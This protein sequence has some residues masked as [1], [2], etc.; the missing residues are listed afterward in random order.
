MAYEFE[1]VWPHL[2]ENGILL[3]DNMPDND[4][5]FY[6]AKRVQAERVLL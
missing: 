5:S 1:T 3:A 6:F 4:S 2:S